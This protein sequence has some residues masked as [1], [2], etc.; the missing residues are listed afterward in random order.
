MRDAIRAAAPDLH[1]TI[2]ADITREF[3]E[4]ERASTTTLAAYVQPVIDRYLG[5]IDYRL[6]QEGFAGRFSVMQ[7]NGGRLPADVDPP[8]PRQ[9]A[10]IGPGGGR[11]GGDAADRAVGARPT[12]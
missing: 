8:Q 9:R 6:A 11:D 12:C 3:R 4:F 1:V 2:S 7:S 10:A 5:R